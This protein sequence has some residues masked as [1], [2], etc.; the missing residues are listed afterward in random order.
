MKNRN[1]KVAKK[2]LIFLMTLIIVVSFSGIGL[3]VFNLISFNV[4]ASK[5]IYLLLGV[6]LLPYEF[7]TQG[8]IVGMFQE[9]GNIVYALIISIAIFVL[10]I[11]LLANSSKMY[12]GKYSSIK[13]AIF[14]VIANVLIF[15][16]TAIFVFGAV[17]ITLKYNQMVNGVNDIGPEFIKIIMTN[18]GFNLIVVKEIVAAYFGSLVCL[19]TL[20]VFIIGMFHKSTKV[21]IIT[22][23]NFYSD[24]YEEDKAITNSTSS[25][26]KSKKEKKEQ[27]IADIPENDPKAKNLIK[28]IMQLE[29]LKNSGKITNVD[30]TRLRQKAI[31]RYKN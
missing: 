5:Y 19:F 30:Y 20:I 14:G 16:F 22:S 13:R 17:M 12:N 26:Q 27:V 7:I 31:R 28:K 23:I 1:I 4:E 8:R 10:T 11:V 25:V 6:F 3:S 18:F 21:K 2:F 15:I 29:E 9:Q 24:E